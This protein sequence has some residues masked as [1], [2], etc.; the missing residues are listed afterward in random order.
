MD[1]LTQN[2]TSQ[3]TL[4]PQKTGSAKTLIIIVLV[5]ALL[6]ALVFAFYTWQ[7][8]QT[9]NNQLTEKE[10][11]Y[12]SLKAEN[13]KLQ[14]DA[15]KGQQVTQ[16]LPNGKTLSY[17]FSE[18]NSHIIWW[19]NKTGEGVSEVSISDDRVF[20]YLA[21]LETSVLKKVCAK[22]EVN[23]T[24]VS[25]GIFDYSKKEFKNNQY[26]NC[27][28]LASDEKFN[29]D[30]ASRTKAKDLLTLT[31]DNVKRFISEATVAQ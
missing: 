2:T 12:T 4:T 19:S 22:E 24:G 21:S 18:P 17:E 10:T 9:I 11:A 25:L 30:Q 14:N 16:T 13:Q 5:V 15:S 23:Q 3:P 27:L 28:V 1:T 7:Q 20:S 6:G 29:D 26:A 8:N 31:T